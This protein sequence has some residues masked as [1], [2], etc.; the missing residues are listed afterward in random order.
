M[1]INNMNSFENFNVNSSPEENPKNRADGL[2]PDK[3][4]ERR[5]KFRRVVQ[6]GLAGAMLLGAAGCERKEAGEPE[7]ATNK[8]EAVES[9]A[10]NKEEQVKS[11]PITRP[12]DSG[13]RREG[14]TTRVDLEAAERQVLWEYFNNLDKGNTPSKDESQARVKDIARK[15]GFGTGGD[16]TASYKNGVPVS[17]KA[18]GRPVPIRQDYY[19]K[20]ELEAVNR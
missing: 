8:V 10:T 19:S 6:A 9:S 4:D 12:G 11:G 7:Q 13:M 3:N 16:L 17:I 15:A 2:K 14:L 1:F 18:D 5:S 20:A